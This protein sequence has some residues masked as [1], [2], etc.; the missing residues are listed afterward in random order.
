MSL[1]DRL[2]LASVTITRTVITTDAYGDPVST[3]TTTI[4]PKA[5]IWSPMQGDRRISD[6]IAKTSTH[7][8]AIEAG[9]YT[10]ADSDKTASHGGTTYKLVG[11]PD[12]VGNRGM[13]TLHGMERIS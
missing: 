13:M 4:V 7:V 9:A 3:T 1:R 10:F 11:H 2:N 6:K 12:D 5:A 8:L